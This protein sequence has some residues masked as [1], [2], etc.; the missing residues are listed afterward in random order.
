MSV[1]SK[2]AEMVEEDNEN[3]NVIMCPIHGEYPASLKTFGCPTCDEE[4]R[5][6]EE[7]E[8]MLMNSRTQRFNGGRR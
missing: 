5:E 6:Q 7:E 8:E 1:M 3:K 4:R 2:F